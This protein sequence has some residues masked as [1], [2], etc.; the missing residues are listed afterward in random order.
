MDN[1]DVDSDS[2][3]SIRKAIKY[4]ATESQMHNVQ[5]LSYKFLWLLQLH[6]PAYAFETYFYIFNKITKALNRATAFLD[7]CERQQ[8]SFNSLLKTKIQVLLRCSANKFP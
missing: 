4:N 8:R 5:V 2:H 1:I 3:V 7:L 6:L